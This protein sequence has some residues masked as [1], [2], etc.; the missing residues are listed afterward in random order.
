MVLFGLPKGGKG[1]KTMTEKKKYGLYDKDGKF[2]CFRMTKRIKNERGKYDVLTARSKKSV[3]DCR[4]KLDAMIADYAKYKDEEK[5]KKPHSEMMFADYC[6]QWYKLNIQFADISDVGKDDYR[7]YVYT[8]IIP[9]FKDFR[10]CD[11]TEDDCQRFM[12]TYV[13]KSK[14]YASKNRMTLRRIFRKAIK[15]HLI[16]D[17]PAE[18]VVLPKTVKGERRPITDDERALILEVAKT[19]YAGPMILTMLYCGLRPVEIRRMKWSWVDFDKN[20]IRVGQSKTDAGTGRIIPIPPQLRAVLLRHKMKRVNEFWVFYKHTK[21]SEGLDENSFR[22]AWL[23]FKREMDILNGARVYRN[24]IVHSTLSDDLCPY[25]LRHTF[26]TDCQAA[27]VPLNVAKELMGHKDVSITAKIY[28]HMVDDVFEQNRQ[29][30]E[31]Y[32]RQKNE[33]VQLA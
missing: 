27:G 33:S 9:Y 24:Q 10:M 18:D 12:N 21:P 7:C 1:V 13:G 2:I 3:L 20:I 17:N 14:A 19:H 25:L 28:T 8:N 26:C 30:L 22:H 31:D 23:N 16:T 29:R 6:D 32:A 4:K 15:Q 5:N 11:I